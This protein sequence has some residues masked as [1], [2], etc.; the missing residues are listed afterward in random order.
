MKRI[1]LLA[2]AGLMAVAPA[3]AQSRKVV[4]QAKEDARLLARQFKTDGYKALDNVKL[5]EAITDYLSD[6]Y[7]DKSLF[8]VVGKATEKNLNEGKARSRQEA[9][10]VYPTAAVRNSF[11]IYKKNRKKYD[12]ICY[13]LIGGGTS[14]G[15]SSSSS[16][17]FNRLDQEV[18]EARQ[19]ARQEA[20][21]EARQQQKEIRKAQAKAEK[22]AEQARKKADKA[23]QKA[24][25]KATEK[26]RK[27]IDKA[28]REREKAL[29]GINY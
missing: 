18:K 2:L 25:D 27:A 10:S 26:A 28:D 4:K 11:F 29:E 15:Y 24:V 12:V 21:K 3:P 19:E 14:R 23:H 16:G 17:G 7:S 13:A 20:R 1:I 6:K 5:E 8:E 22:K 9:L